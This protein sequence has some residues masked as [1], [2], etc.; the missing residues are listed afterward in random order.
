MSDISITIPPWLLL[1]LLGIEA[2]PVALVLALSTGVMAVLTRG[3]WRVAALLVTG[4]LVLD[5]AAAGLF[6][7]Q[8]SSS[9][10][11]AQA[12]E[13]SIHSTLDTV[14]VIDGV[15]LPAQTEVTWTDPSHAHLRQASPPQPTNILGVK[16]DWME[17][18]ADG[19]WTVQLTSPQAIDGWTCQTTGVKLGRDGHLRGCSLSAGRNWNGWPI[20]AGTLLN[21]DSPGKTIGMVFPANRPVM[22]HEIGRPLPATGSMSMNADG[23]L[24]RVYF[25][26]NA[27]LVVRGIPLWNTVT[28][29]Y[30]ASTFGQGRDRPPI[31]YN[32]A[33]PT[34]LTYDG[35]TILPGTEVTIRLSDGALTV[36]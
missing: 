26:N 33:I 30:A 21:L 20:P 25:E 10:A 3:A 36:K 5:L 11:K 13:A 2:W 22:A 31:A 6:W 34:E 27:P 32:G 17:R 8:R 35:R 16:A 29:D 18:E 7:V 1:I 14:R 12:F 24:N 15:L 23:S 9:D 4:L 28:W 19:R